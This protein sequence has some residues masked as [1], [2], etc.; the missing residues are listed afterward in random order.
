MGGWKDLSEYY[1]TEEQFRGKNWYFQSLK[2]GIV[3]YNS[4]VTFGLNETSIFLS[5][6]PIFRIGHP[7][8]LIPLKELQGTEYKGLFFKYVDI[9]PQK[10][11]GQT[12]RLFRKQAD[13]IEQFTKNG[14]Q[15]E[16]RS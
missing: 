14:W 16:R 7:P 2:L 9:I 6:L 3:N 1:R 4:C 15:Y 12:I 10:A 8:L 5:V 13:R 11:K